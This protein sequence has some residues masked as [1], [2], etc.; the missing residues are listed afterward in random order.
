MDFLTNHNNN[1]LEKRK[2]KG[3]LFFCL[4]RTAS[5][6]VNNYIFINFFFFKYTIFQII[7]MK[8]EG[9]I[10][11]FIQKVAEIICGKAT[12]CGEVKNCRNSQKIQ[13]FRQKLRPRI[14]RVTVPNQHTLSK[15]YKREF[16]TLHWACICPSSNQYASSISSSFWSKLV[17]ED[18]H[19][20][21]CLFILIYFDGNNVTFQQSIVEKK[22]WHQT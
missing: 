6:P 22:T 17:S 7:L 3:P 19:F 9:K 20:L 21:N 8:I 11:I 2:C 5:L 12:I 13:K 15:F 10:S 1:K 16:F 4:F 14:S 18:W